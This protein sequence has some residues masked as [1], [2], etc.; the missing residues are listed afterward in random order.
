M[1]AR[2]AFLRRMIPDA[3]TVPLS[4]VVDKGGERLLFVEEGGA[5]RARSI[6]IGVIQRDRV[7]I[8]KGL[9]PG[10]RVIVTGQ[11]N[12]EDGIPVEVR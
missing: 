11:N 1:I 4:A 2:V 8:V 10:D 7:Q 5:A 3:L 9:S 12:V 6:E